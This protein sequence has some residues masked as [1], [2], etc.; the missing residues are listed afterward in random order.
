[1]NLVMR[2]KGVLIMTR[3]DYE[4]SRIRRC[5]DYKGVFAANIHEKEQMHTSKS[6]Q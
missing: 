6:E 4:A 1:M 5:P 3:P 2:T